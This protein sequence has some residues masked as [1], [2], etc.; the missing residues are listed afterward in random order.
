MQLKLGFTEN[1][2]PQ[3]GAT[4]GAKKNDKFCHTMFSAESKQL[5]DFSEKKHKLFY[6]TLWGSL[7]I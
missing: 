1:C 2:S 3:H 5:G 7:P 4:N 6:P